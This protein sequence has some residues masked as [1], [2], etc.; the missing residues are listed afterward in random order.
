M[1]NFVQWNRDTLLNSPLFEPLWPSLQSID[2]SGF[3]HLADL[4][5]QLARQMPI[6]TRSGKCLRFV[7]QGQGRLVFEEQYE[8]RCYLTGEVQTRENNWHDLFNALVWLT[9][10]QSKA[11]INAR[12]Y[13]ALK[14]AEVGKQSIK[15]QRGTVR[16]MATLF[17]ESG[18]IVV[19]ADEYLAHALNNFKWKALFWM[20]R[21]AVQSTMGF[22]IFGHG[23]YEKSMHPYVGITGQGLLIKVAHAFFTWPLAQRLAYLDAQVAAYLNEVSH[24]QDTHEL[25]PVPLLG[26]PGWS[27]EN[28]EVA[29]YDNSNYFRSGRSAALRT[30]AS[31][32]SA[33][34]GL[35]K[36]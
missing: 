34:N 24:C 21:A 14:N 15:S 12:H 31:N 11:A 7:A 19:Y 29:Y 32:S 25:T 20:H 1:E 10:P 9:F 4:N 26:I 36:K 6:T 30:N 22:Y 28:E 33:G 16:D 18:V 3:P 2:E 27:A 8:P 17:D 23:L 5:Q 35:L 13:D